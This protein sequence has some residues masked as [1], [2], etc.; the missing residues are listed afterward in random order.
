MMTADLPDRARFAEYA[1][2]QMQNRRFLARED[3]R[4]L[5]E[6]ALTRFNLGLDDATGLLRNAAED[7]QVALEQE[8]GASS[9]QLLKTM[10]DRRGRVARADFDRAVAF[11]RARAGGGVTEMDAKRRMK[12]LMEEMDLQPRPTGRLIRSRRWYRVIEA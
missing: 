10:A 3:E 2:L 6:E 9:R 11:F 7:G 5:L 12:R 1:K 8:L 4:R